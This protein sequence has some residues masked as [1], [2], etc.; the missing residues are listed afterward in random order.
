[1]SKWNPD[2]NKLTGSF[3][4]P[5]VSAVMLLDS[6]GKEKRAR[7]EWTLGI[8]FFFGGCYLPYILGDRYD[9]VGQLLCGVLFSIIGAGLAAFL[10][11]RIRKKRKSPPQ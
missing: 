9:Q 1:M 8:P 3:V 2:P 11:R 4:E 7:G 5:M 10:N 6:C